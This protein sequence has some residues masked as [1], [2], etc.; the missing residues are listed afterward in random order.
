MIKII[1]GEDLEHPDHMEIGP[2]NQEDTEYLD[3]GD[4]DIM[5]DME[6]VMGAKTGGTGGGGG[7]VPREPPSNL[8]KPPTTGLQLQPD[9]Q[10][11]ELPYNSTDPVQQSGCIPDPGVQPEP[12][13]WDPWDTGGT[14]GGHTTCI[15][16][17]SPTARDST[18]GRAGGSGR[19]ERPRNS[20]SSRQGEGAPGEP[21]GTVQQINNGENVN[22]VHNNGENG[23]NSVY[24]EKRK[25]RGYK[26]TKIV[27][28]NIQGLLNR[29]KYKV[30]Q[31]NDIA[32][33]LSPAVI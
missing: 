2:N 23:K 13:P 33:E 18:T 32:M 10:S 9:L 4:T 22:N 30:E 31:L 27:T 28:L 7:G 20:G 17:D 8:H 1:E 24:W 26:A 11:N 29:D 14:G 21:P 15:P 5:E 3:M 25:G 19:S 12:D 6:E 16:T